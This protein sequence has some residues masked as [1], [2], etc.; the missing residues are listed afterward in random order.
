MG[1]LT[2][3]KKGG[4]GSWTWG[5]AQ[6]VERLPSRHKALSS[7]PTTARKQQ[8]KTKR[9]E[10]QW[11]KKKVCKAVFKDK[12]FWRKV[13]FLPSSASCCLNNLTIPYNF[14]RT[15]QVSGFPRSGNSIARTDSPCPS[16][17]SPD[18]LSTGMGGPHQS[19]PPRHLTPAS[20]PNPNPNPNQVLPRKHF[21]QHQ[22]QTPDQPPTSPTKPTCY[23]PGC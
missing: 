9:N 20:N 6:V 1:S 17:V 14:S 2:I 22:G 12:L 11:K 15:L 4:L 23:L 18:T 13:K 5:E 3:P 19:L 8:N 21:S 16:P 10:V 7:N